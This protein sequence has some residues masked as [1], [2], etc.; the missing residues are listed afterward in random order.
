ME[1]V[2]NNTVGLYGDMQC[3]IGGEM[4]SALLAGNRFFDAL[5]KIIDRQ[6][7]NAVSAALCT[8]LGYV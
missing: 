6:I 8:T 3:V 7:L 1:R 2:I 5:R 4:L